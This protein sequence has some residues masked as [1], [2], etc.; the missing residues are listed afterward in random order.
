M[1]RIRFA[2]A[3]AL[4][5]LAMPA[6]AESTR[7]PDGRAFLKDPHA[8]I[9]K[10]VRVTSIG[11]VDPGDGFLCATRLDGQVLVIQA[12]ALGPLTNQSIAESLIGPCKGTANLA[13]RRC[14]VNALVEVRAV[15]Q[16]MVDTDEGSVQRV[17]L[18]A[19]VIEMAR[20]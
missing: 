11:C 6:M 8:F 12:T 20:P 7:V 17:T 5:L 1:G 10:H 18:Q 14:R 9:G 16:E 2:S 13:A 15:A 4:A 3:A 19:G